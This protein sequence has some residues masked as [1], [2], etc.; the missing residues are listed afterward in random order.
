EVRTTN[1]LTPEK[2]WYAVHGSCEDDLMPQTSIEMT[3]DERAFEL[4]TSVAPDDHWATQASNGASAPRPV[5][6]WLQ[7]HSASAAW[8]ASAALQ[9]Q[10]SR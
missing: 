3:L 10:Q 9:A 1:K 4:Q 2:V 8:A 7:E 6:R 5:E